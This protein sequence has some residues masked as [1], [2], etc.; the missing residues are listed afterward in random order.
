MQEIRQ[1]QSVSKY[2]ALLTISRYHTVQL[3]CNY[4]RVLLCIQYCYLTASTWL[5]NFFDT[6]MYNVSFL[7]QF[8]VPASLCNFPIHFISINTSSYYIIF[9]YL[10]Y[11]HVF[12]IYIQVLTTATHLRLSTR[13]ET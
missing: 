11:L 1:H 7:V 9:K 5:N 10:L 6:Q 4:Y 13:H 3:L 12:T 8:Y 2:L